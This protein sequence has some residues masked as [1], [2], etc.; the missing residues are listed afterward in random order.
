MGLKEFRLFIVL[1]ITIYL[2][3]G[4]A[5][6]RARHTSAFTP[7]KKIANVKVAKSM[8]QLDKI[9]SN[10]KPILIYS[11][12]QK[13]LKKGVKFV[14]LKP[15]KRVI[16]NI[17]NSV[18]VRNRAGYVFWDEHLAKAAQAHARDMATSNFI[19]HLGSGSCLDFARKD[20]KHG[21]NFYERILFFGYPIKATQL[22]GEIIT[23][24]KDR[25]VLSKEP[26]PHFKHAVENFLKSPTHSAILN[27]GRF[28]DVG[29]AAYKI[30]GKVYWVI[31]LGEAGAIYKR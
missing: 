7:T 2:I 15:Y 10:I 28:T 17:I 20:S 23:Y 9:C 12:P 22:A 27:N 5:T 29:V 31:E 18:R 19:G 25:V 11:Y 30:K 21:S 1:T 8:K 26:M 16:L 6:T 3:N 14:N 13:S 24:T 4:C